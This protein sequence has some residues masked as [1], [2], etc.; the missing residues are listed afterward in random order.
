[1][2]IV[3]GMDSISI[4]DSADS[5]MTDQKT[6]NTNETHLSLIDPCS[7]LP[8]LNTLSTLTRLIQKCLVHQSQMSVGAILG[9]FHVIKLN[10]L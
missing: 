4:D 1:M 3:E 8:T 6:Q 5:F 7:K 2:T 10:L 9:E